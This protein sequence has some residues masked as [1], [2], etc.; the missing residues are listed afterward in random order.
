MLTQRARDLLLLPTSF[1]KKLLT[2]L[3]GL[4]QGMRIVD[5]VYNAIS[6]FAVKSTSQSALYRELPSVD[7]LLRRDDLRELSETAGHANVADA[8]RHLLAKLRDAISKG[9]HDEESLSRML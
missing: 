9:Q 4:L 1:S 2:A 7:E 3:P 6:A 8:A 5:L